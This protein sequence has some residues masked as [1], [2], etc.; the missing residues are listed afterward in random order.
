MKE[1]EERD[2]EL[3]KKSNNL[4][5][6]GKNQEIEAGKYENYIIRDEDSVDI[7]NINEI[8]NEKEKAKSGLDE[9][10]LESVHGIL[11]NEKR[12]DD[13][14]RDFFR[15]Q[16]EHAPLELN[17][18]NEIAET[19]IEARDVQK[20]AQMILLNGMEVDLSGKKTEEIY[21]EV[22][23]EAA[24][25]IIAELLT[26]KRNFEYGGMLH[27]KQEEGESFTPDYE[28][29]NENMILD[30][31]TLNDRI[32]TYK[33]HLY[34]DDSFKHAVEEIISA[35][36]KSPGNNE[37]ESVQISG[38]EI[39]DAYKRTRRIELNDKMRHH[40]YDDT[41]AGPIASRQ[42][43]LG[44]KDR[45]ALEELQQEM[46]DYNHG[47]VRK[48]VNA[49]M[50]KA[51]SDVLNNDKDGKLTMQDI[52]ELRKRAARYYSDRKGTFFG[53]RTGEGKNRLNASA[54]IFRT[55]DRIFEKLSAQE[56]AKISDE[57]E[58][59]RQEEERARLKEAQEKEKAAKELE[60]NNEKL[61]QKQ[62][63]KR[64]QGIE[65]SN[66]RFM[67]YLEKYDFDAKFQSH[68]DKS[69][70]E[71]KTGGLVK[72]T[73]ALYIREY[74]K[75][76]GGVPTRKDG[77]QVD[78]TQLQTELTTSADFRNAIGISKDKTTLTGDDFKRAKNAATERTKEG[79][80]KMR[81][82]LV[83]KLPCL[84]E[85]MK[86]QEFK[87]SLQPKQAMKK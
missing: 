14:N 26:K 45:M 64:E 56:F 41:E 52:D 25:L 81:Q 46:L 21:K 78:L 3:Q 62:R 9:D 86:E 43:R 17:D 72:M 67:K 30:S 85:T 35:K 71:I 69:N 6:A 70:K 84:K 65:N 79:K 29:S 80:L 48:G 36:M 58:R 13:R 54:R 32:D 87:K 7:V 2:E 82:T 19:G 75:E 12:I 42:V 39:V 73:A 53:P 22:R 4:G 74:L 16:R 11:E 37:L 8:R 31:A 59:S 1:A 28:K 66:E 15:I 76:I 10:D 40:Y 57:D 34:Q 47:A 23:N 24:N 63:E 49:K 27:Q 77:K 5:N 33:K 61:F 60:A 20:N 44:V 83:D 55:S 68:K 18:G 51:L 50:M 38:S